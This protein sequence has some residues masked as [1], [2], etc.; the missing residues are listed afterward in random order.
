MK[1]L[2]L[3]GL[4]AA[5]I[6]LVGCA[7][8]TIEEESQLDEVTESLTVKHDLGETTLTDTPSSIAVLEYSFLDAL[9][10]LGVNP[11]AIA[12]D[13]QSSKVADITDGTLTEY[14]SLGARKEPNLEEMS[15]L[16][17]DLIVADTVRHSEIYDDLSKIAPTVALTS[18]DTTY[19]QFIESFKL[20]ATIVDKQ[21]E[22]ENLISE[23]EAQFDTVSA[24]LSEEVKN[25]SILIVSPKNDK[26]TAHTSS[27]FVGQVLEKAGLKN[28]IESDEVEVDLS[29]E[30]LV[31]IDADVIIYMRD[32]LDTTIYSE[33]VQTD[34]Y[35]ALTAV[36]SN[37]VYVT[38]QK[39]FWTQYRGFAAIEFIL[40][41]LE[42]W[43]IQ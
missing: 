16:D 5:G 4:V 25:Q 10:R 15:L 39:E 40:G 1:K 35:Q 30:Q 42:N 22:A 19:D 12:D 6:T 38:G 2:L 11:I 43:F 37:Q 41:E 36:Q 3:M 34:L 18:T 29:L 20:L 28:V 17:V 33:W 21:A 32:D 31:E 8:P 23:T 26:Y 7:N 24:K 13:S 9:Y 14:Q 27:S